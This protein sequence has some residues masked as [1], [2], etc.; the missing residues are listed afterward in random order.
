M[1]PIQHIL[2][3]ALAEVLRRA[4]LTP[5]KVAFAWRASVGPG[6]SKVTTVELRGQVLH[7]RAKNASW[8]REIE[9]SIGIV[10]S[11]MEALLGPDVVRDIQVRAD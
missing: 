1:I 6:I 2:P 4:P 3:T 11:R 8:Q 7:V 5:E 10:R 9:R